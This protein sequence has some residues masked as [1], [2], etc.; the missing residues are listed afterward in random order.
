MRKKYIV[1]FDLDAGR[2][3]DCSNKTWCSLSKIVMNSCIQLHAAARAVYIQAK[4][5]MVFNPLHEAGTSC[6]KN[7]AAVQKQYPNRDQAPLQYISKPICM[8][9]W[10]RQMMPLLVLKVWKTCNNIIIIITRQM[11]ALPTFPSPHGR[12]H[13]QEYRP[14][15]WRRW[16][17]HRRWKSYPWLHWLYILPMPSH[18]SSGIEAAVL[19]QGSHPPT[20]TQ[21]DQLSLT[22]HTNFTTCTC[23]FELVKMQLR[24]SPQRT[25]SACFKLQQLLWAWVASVALTLLHNK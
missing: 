4:M 25:V 5:L 22:C 11:M 24:F 19:A 16:G 13:T 20:S 23:S 3:F 21:T 12:G 7:Q 14:P 9:Q 17:Y 6:L 1:Q 2:L 10:T 8:H 18:P 15:D